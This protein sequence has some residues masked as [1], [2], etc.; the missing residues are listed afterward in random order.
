M[1]IATAA[2]GM[3]GIYELGRVLLRSKDKS[4]DKE[5]SGGAL[6]GLGLMGAGIVSQGVA[7][8]LR[9]AASRT[10]EL[11]ADHA[12]AQAFGADAMVSA[13][14]KIETH[15]SRRPA[16]LRDGRAGRA[17]A[18]LMISDGGS[19]ASKT[20]KGLLEKIGNALRTH[21]PTDERIEAL[22]KSAAKGE[23]P[24]RAPAAAGWPPFLA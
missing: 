23:V 9:L 4:N 1:H 3:G 6:V 2:A 17:Y 22:E 11:K 21:P 15:A 7:H 12:A 5:E 13:L 8:M 24:R 16:D 14:R 20:E 18:H 10:A 19:A